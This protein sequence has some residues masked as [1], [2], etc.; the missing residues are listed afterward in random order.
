MTGKAVS[1]CSMFVI[2]A[3]EFAPGALPVVA[4]A[5]GVVCGKASWPPQAKGEMLTVGAAGE[6]VSAL[7]EVMVLS[8][9]DTADALVMAKRWNRGG[10]CARR[11]KSLKSSYDRV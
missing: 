7:G 2:S 9:F 6:V 10:R 11:C 1:T 3:L 4:V 8:T 5:G